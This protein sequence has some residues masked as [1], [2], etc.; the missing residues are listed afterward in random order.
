MANKKRKPALGT[1][2]RLTRLEENY[3]SM[4]EDITDIRKHVTNHIMHELA[5]VK[6]DLELLLDRK[7][8]GDAVKTFLHHLMQLS[9]SLAA[10]TW[11]VIQIIRT[12]KGWGLGG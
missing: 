1:E 4:G 9:V 12:F 11:A 3:K 6:T 8:A 5:E 2:H 7:K 10:L